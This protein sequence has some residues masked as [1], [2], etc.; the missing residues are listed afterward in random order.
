M[1]FRYKNRN[2]QLLSWTVDTATT[3]AK[4]TGNK[5]DEWKWSL[6]ILLVTTTLKGHQNGSQSIDNES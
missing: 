2:G 1:F 3:I 5:L 4:K 6:G